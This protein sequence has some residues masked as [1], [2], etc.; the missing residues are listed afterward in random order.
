MQNAFRILAVV[1]T[2]QSVGCA[3]LVGNPNPAI[4][5]D[6]SSQ[7]TVASQP[8]TTMPNYEGNVVAWQYSP[9]VA[10]STSSNSSLNAKATVVVEADRAAKQ[11]ARR[12][13]DQRFADVQKEVNAQLQQRQS[14]P[15]VTEAFPPP[16]LPVDATSASSEPPRREVKKKL[17]LDDAQ[18]Q[19]AAST[20][21]SPIAVAPQPWQSMSARPLAIVTMVVLVLSGVTWPLTRS[22]RIA[23]LFARFHRP[24]E[25]AEAKST[26]DHSDST[27]ST[28][29][30]SEPV[31]C[32]DKESL[33]SGFDNNLS[34]FSIEAETCFSSC[35]PIAED[36]QAW[37]SELES[38]STDFMVVCVDSWSQ[39]DLNAPRADKSE[40]VLQA[41]NATNKTAQVTELETDANAC[42]E[43]DAVTNTEDEAQTNTSTPE[44]IAAETVLPVAVKSTATSCR[45]LIAVNQRIVI[46]TPR[47]L[48]APSVEH[49][50]TTDCDMSSSSSIETSSTATTSVAIVANARPRGV[51]LMGLPAKGPAK[52]VYPKLMSPVQV[53]NEVEPQNHICGESVSENAARATFQEFD[54]IGSAQKFV[55]FVVLFAED[56][57]I[58]SFQKLM[59][60]E[61]FQLKD[62]SEL[63]AN[64][65]R[66]A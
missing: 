52:P 5:D 26:L 25:N 50:E 59:I 46:G 22:Q 43:T 39:N 54:S 35:D 38:A 1:L 28:A 31:T 65:V 47:A 27:H 61:S 32:C 42:V 56:G 19:Q 44:S 48:L 36:K 11:E 16:S 6:H 23:Q 14:A 64:V 49:S 9:I 30:P 55:G 7:Q 51:S 58:G 29:A 20:T 8:N 41:S 53:R 10:R 12:Q 34:S 45:A 3:M 13:R 62:Q 24:E 15:V 57:T 37:L 63:T 17:Y 4:Q 33:S 18:F 40:E 66:V 2:T 21:V 60:V